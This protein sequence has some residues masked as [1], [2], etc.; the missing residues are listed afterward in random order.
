M[1]AA[2]MARMARMRQMHRMIRPPMSPL[3]YIINKIKSRLFNRRPKVA[4][5]RFNRPGFPPMP[6]PFPRPPLR[7]RIIRI[8]PGRTPKRMFDRPNRIR[9]PQVQRPFPIIPRI[10]RVFRPFPIIPRP[11]PTMV[12]SNRGP[13]MEFRQMQKMHYN[14]PEVPQIPAAPKVEPTSPT[15]IPADYPDNKPFPQIPVPDKEPVG[16]EKPFPTIPVVQFRPPA[17][18][19]R[20]GI[21]PE[22]EQQMMQVDLPHNPVQMP[23]LIVEEGPMNHGKN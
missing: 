22:E 23:D 5:L 3:P 4:L 19:M 21:L 9:F 18:Q 7:T 17:T 8:V 12:L 20:E 10:P 6:R 2:H 11:V 1:A 16:S 15:Q 14:E 13:N